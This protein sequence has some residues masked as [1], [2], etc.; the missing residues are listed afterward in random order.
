MPLPSLA[1]TLQ[2]FHWMYEPRSW[3]LDA[4]LEVKTDPDTDYWQRTHYGFRRDNGHFFY[5]ELDGDFTLAASL[6]YEPTAQY[7]QCGVMCRVDAETW[8]KCSAEY[9]TPAFSRLGSVVTNLGYS[10]WATQDIPATV[11]EI[12]YKLNRK[13]DDFMLSWSTD[14]QEW[15]QMRI[16]HLHRCPRQLQA[17]IYAASPVGPGFVCRVYDLQIGPNDWTAHATG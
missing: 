11:N 15:L 2:S 17:G 14:G 16:T 10:D 8:V 1:E 5:T 3:R 7:D 6:T 12:H 9:E 4:V 13:G